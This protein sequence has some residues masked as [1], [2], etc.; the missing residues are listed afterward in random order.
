[1]SDNP[2]R[3]RD[4]KG[5]EIEMGSTGTTKAEKDIL[6]DRCKRPKSDAGTN[7][8]LMGDERAQRRDP[9]IRNTQKAK[10]IYGRRDRSVP[11]WRIERSVSV[12]SNRFR[13]A[14]WGFFEPASTMHERERQ[15][16]AS[17]RP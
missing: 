11:N 12:C 17:P 14:T 9:K 8:K 16:W 1:M 7:G 3:I 15:P 10:E 2:E 13:S 4:K 5:P 6:I